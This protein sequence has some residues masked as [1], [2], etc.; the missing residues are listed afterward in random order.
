MH[1]QYVGKV[2]L[3]LKCSVR[4]SVGLSLVIA[5]LNKSNKDKVREVVSMGSVCSLI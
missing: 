4:F 5:L 2:L 3:F 1:K